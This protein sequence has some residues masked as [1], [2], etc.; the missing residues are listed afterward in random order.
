MND[1]IRGLIERTSGLHHKLGGCHP[2]LSRGLVWCR[3]C[4]RE[5]SVSASYSMKHG[6]PKCCGATM[7][8]DSPDEQKAMETPNAYSPHQHHHRT[9]RGVA[10]HFGNVASKGR[11]E[12]RATASLD[13]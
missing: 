12:H 4:G 8:I 7:T 9:G 11:C 1:N 10:A 2:K 3:S 5:Q 13:R 6:W